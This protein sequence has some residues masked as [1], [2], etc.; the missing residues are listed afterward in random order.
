M[1]RTVQHEKFKKAENNKFWRKQT[2]AT[3]REIKNEGLKF[4]GGRIFE[5][6][7]QKL[8]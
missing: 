6:V 8:R 1:A 2:K 5:G 7:K 3:E 4:W